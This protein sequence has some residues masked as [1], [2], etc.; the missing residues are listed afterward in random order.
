MIT[1]LHALIW[2]CTIARGRGLGL[3]LDEDKPL[4]HG[5]LIPRET[6]HI[7]S[8]TRT[9][10]ILFLLT[11]GKNKPNSRTVIRTCS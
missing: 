10:Q 9:K 4:D 8:R 7:V 11:R 6:R 1:C 5:N 3:P 2:F